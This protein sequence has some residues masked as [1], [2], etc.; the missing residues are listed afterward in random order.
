MGAC[1]KCEDQLQ[2]SL[3]ALKES[4]YK[5]TKTRYTIA[6]AICE[7]HTPFSP[8]DVHDKIKNEFKEQIDFV[9]GLFVHIIYRG[10]RKKKR[11]T[12]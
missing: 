10:V 11:T 8:K 7:F 9:C 6:K 12:P 4:G 5:Q 2:A 1:D 3:Q